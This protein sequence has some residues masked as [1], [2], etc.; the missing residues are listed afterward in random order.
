MTGEVWEVAE[1]MY[2]EKGNEYGSQPYE[3]GTQPPQG[4]QVGSQQVIIQ[5]VPTEEIKNEDQG[6]ENIW[7]I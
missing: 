7:S 5:F 4:K 3:Y 1:S 2:Y 6:T